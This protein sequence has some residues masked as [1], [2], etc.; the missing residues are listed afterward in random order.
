MKYVETEGNS[1]DDAIDR[2]LAE[3]G[4]SR[5][6]V[7]IEIL[8]NSARGLFGFGG[9]RARV[10]A[11]LRT[12]LEATAAEPFEAVARLQT[13]STPAAKA[14]TTPTRAA[15]PRTEVP[16]DARTLERVREV[17]QEVVRLMGSEAVVEAVGQGTE[18]A[19][20][21]INGDSSGRLIGRRGQTLDALEYLANRI[22]SRDDEQASRIVV[23]SQNYR[24]RRRQSLEELA[25]R[26][27]ERARRRGK[28]VVLNPMS[29]RDRRVIHLALQNDRSLTTRSSGQG[30]FRR[31]VV[32][33]EGGRAQPRSE[34]PQRRKDEKSQGRQ[35]PEA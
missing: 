34:R 7:D 32:I 28:P 18:A 15:A 24:Q 16:V 19:R 29:P 1:I 13:G 35:T 22:A 3:L 14:E 8:S 17:L 33:P 26:M 21:V 2:A 12:P 23:D 27:A 4:A 11:T 31:L 25:H 5:D 10:R 6:K 20:L 9:K 30:Y